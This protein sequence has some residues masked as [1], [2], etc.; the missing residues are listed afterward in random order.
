MCRL[1]AAQRAVCPDLPGFEPAHF[2]SGLAPAHRAGNGA[3]QLA[4][5]GAGSGVRMRLAPAECALVSSRCQGHGLAGQAAIGPA[6][7]L[8]SRHWP[9]ARTSSAHA[10]WRRHFGLFLEPSS[11]PR[12]FLA[13]TL[14]MAPAAPVTTGYCPRRFAGPNG[15]RWRSW[16]ASIA[17]RSGRAHRHRGVCPRRP[18]PRSRAPN[19]GPRLG[20]VPLECRVCASRHATAGSR[21]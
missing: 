2:H 4:S 3:P 12:A 9:D 15:H 7:G 10:S 11:V 13:R 19:S 1:R 17:H 8:V 14:W 18:P 20:P 5:S 21:T 16:P 6:I